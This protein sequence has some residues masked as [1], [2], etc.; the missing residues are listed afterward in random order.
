MG[1]FLTDVAGVFASGGSCGIKKS[2]LDFAYIYAPQ[3]VGSAGVFTKNAFA[4]ACVTHNKQI[5]KQSVIK[6]VV[7]NSG[8]ANAVTGEQGLRSAAQT[9][10]HAAELLGIQA[11]Q[12]A[13]AST[14][15]IG[16]QLPLE[17]VLSGI[18]TIMNPPEKLEGEITAKAIMTTDTCAKTC[19]YEAA[20][21][22]HSL[23]IAG[24]AKG[25]GM[26]APNMATML[27][28]IVTN[29]SFSSSALQGILGEAVEDSFNMMSVD[30][31]TS[32]NDMV[33]VI[34]SGADPITER[35]PGALDSFAA[36]LRK[37]CT[38][39]ACQIVRDGEGAE[40]VIQVEVR[41][42]CSKADARKI[43][44]SVIDSPLVKTAV[45]GADPNWGRVLMAV[46]KV[47]GVQVVPEKTDLAF[48]GVS[49]LQAGTPQ[50]F[51]RAALIAKLKQPTVTV[52]INLNLGQHS[53]T[54]WGCDLT[55]GYIDINTAYN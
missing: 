43:A 44:K 4:A 53:A 9:A 34:S 32:T 16:V 21:G 30:T 52:V 51:D 41:G 39:L 10:A 3:A 26:I 19:F 27:G 49:L 1:K 23:Q 5:L 15:I 45:H 6:A 7:I 13:V 25:A 31:D 54:A 40:K 33:I 8:N 17:K 35:T 48:E 24:I 47:E 37:A 12:V 18:S 11:N 36:L 46:G 42:A 20:C 38:D 55:K 2:G 29:A 22:E 14:G 28:F 50:E